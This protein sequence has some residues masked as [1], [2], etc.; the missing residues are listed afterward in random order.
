MRRDCLGRSRASNAGFAEQRRGSHDT[1]D[2]RHAMFGGGILHAD[3]LGEGL[4][5]EGVVRIL[6]LDRRIDAA[7]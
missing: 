6:R 1:T 5:D 4:L 3:A 7:A 2:I